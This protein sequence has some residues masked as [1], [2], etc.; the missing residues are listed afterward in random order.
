MAGPILHVGA[1]VNC[2]HG[3]AMQV[4][5]GSGRVLVD[6]KPA[7][8]MAD[9]FPVA[10]CPFQIPVGAGTK[11]SPCVQVQWTVPATRVQV[12]GSPVI[13]ALSTGLG[14]SPE[15]APQGPPVPAT[16]QTR[17]IAI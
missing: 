5:P 9:S 6:N 14:M 15:S 10:G 17:V 7:A 4:A 16:T 3:A 13:T 2:T 11:P 1:T 8:T 12:N